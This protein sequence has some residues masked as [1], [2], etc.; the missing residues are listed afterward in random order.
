MATSGGSSKKILIGAIAAGVLL[1]VGGGAW[2][3]RQQNANSAPVTTAATVNGG[4]D[5]SNGAQ[6]QTQSQAST[7]PVGT[8]TA[9][10]APTAANAGIST[11]S[12]AANGVDTANAVSNANKKLATVDAP[13]S[14]PVIQPKKPSLGAVNLSA[15]VVNRPAFVQDHAEEALNLG[16]SN[17]TG[18]GEGLS[19]G[20]VASS[21]QPMAPPAP[22]P[23]GGDVK[24]AR[25]LSSVAPQY[26]AMA[27]SQ[28][29]GGD[30]KID[31]LVDV[32]GQVAGMKVISGPV[33]LQQPAMDALRRWK[34]E[35]AQLNGKTVPMHLTV[36]IQF[37]LQ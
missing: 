22:L 25:L 1:A 19:S 15:P 26:P 13:V 33:L 2:Y 17:A 27:R 37:K 12:N 16:A 20:L 34:Y 21:K 30:V 8:Y 11:G 24:S 36:T 3:V 9:V 5:A 6:L 32:T 28:R 10:S 7:S 4:T 18:G 35:P 23:V 14:A 29:I 31:A